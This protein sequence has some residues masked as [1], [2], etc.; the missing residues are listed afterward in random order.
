[1]FGLRTFPTAFL[2]LGG[3]GGD[4]FKSIFGMEDLLR[5]PMI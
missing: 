1:M 3:G 2:A 5:F 4:F